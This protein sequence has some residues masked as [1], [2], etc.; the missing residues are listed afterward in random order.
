[1]SGVVVATVMQ[2]VGAA[3]SWLAEKAVQ[4]PLDSKGYN[5]SKEILRDQMADG[6]LTKILATLIVEP[7][8]IVTESARQSKVYDKVATIDLDIFTSFYVQVFYVLTQLYNKADIEAIDLLSTNR[9]TGKAMIETARRKLIKNGLELSQEDEI[10]VPTTLN[11]LDFSSALFYL[12]NEDI[13]QLNLEAR[14]NSGNNYAREKLDL[15]RDR[16]ELE[17]DKLEYQK[18]IDALKTGDSRASAKA[19]ED[20]DRARFEHEQNK[21]RQDLIKFEYDRKKY[22]NDAHYRA[23]VDNARIQQQ[24]QKNQLDS[25]KIELDKNKYIQDAKYRAERDQVRDAM[26]LRKLEREEELRNEEKENEKIA[27]REAYLENIDKDSLKQLLIRNVELS[28]S[29]QN[30][31]DPKGGWKTFKMPITIVGTNRIVSFDELRL[32]VSNYD[33]KKSFKY[34]WNEWRSGGIS[35]MNLIF[36][37]D[38]IQEYKK[39]KLSKSSRLFTDIEDAKNAAIIRKTVTGNIGAESSYNMVI[40]T[41][42]EADALS[43]LYKKDLNT[44]SGYQEFLKVMNAHNLTIL[45][46]DNERVKICITDIRNHMD[47][48]YSRLM[49][50]DD[51][52]N[53]LMDFFKNLVTGSVPKF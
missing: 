29:K 6:R 19:R 46:E 20:L 12:N 5:A 16:L 36:A 14:N 50:R 30:L 21:L 47:I 2:A 32:A 25:A 8:I 39:N 53:N 1:M 10:S 33:Y 38:L 11:Q 51:K 31:D 3:K 48:G 28:L 41:Q 23:Q 45:D 24:N 42:Y 40:M 17:R 27:R 9:Y 26:E 7:T 13:R 43:K 49:K 22:E 4:E 35:L 18:A 44:Y 37:G 34:R 15:D 52:E